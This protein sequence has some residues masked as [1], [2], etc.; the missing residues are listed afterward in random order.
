MH[1]FS[2]RYLGEEEEGQSNGESR[3]KSL[4]NKLQERAKARELQSRATK[5]S[6][7]QHT[8]T[9]KQSSVGKTKR[10]FEQQ[11]KDKR[12]PKKKKESF[13]DQEDA[14]DIPAEHTDLSESD[15]K[16]KKK[17]GNGMQEEKQHTGSCM[18]KSSRKESEGI[19]QKQTFFFSF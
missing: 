7:V 19:L 12:Q 4:L 1:L 6:D 16:K 14:D 5:E 13:K 15:Q 18:H 17:K 2:F 11:E 9:S 3:S 10:K 8:K